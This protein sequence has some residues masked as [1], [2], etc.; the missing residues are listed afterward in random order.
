MK[1]V[2]KQT[3]VEELLGQRRQH[4][5]SVASG[6]NDTR[7]HLAVLSRYNTWRVYSYINLWFGL[8][9]YSTVSVLE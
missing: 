8:W 1:G 3:I 4:S 2:R 6:R 5:N 7:V 9:F